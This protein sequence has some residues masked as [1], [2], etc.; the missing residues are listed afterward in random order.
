MRTV[1]MATLCAT[2]IV[3][4]LVPCRAAVKS[5]GSDASEVRAGEAAFQG[6]C[7]VCHSAEPG[8]RLVGPSLYGTTGGA[9]P[10]MTD[11]AVRA[12]VLNGKG[13][14]LDFKGVLSSGDIDN[15]LAYLRTLG[16][17]KGN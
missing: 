9:H 17:S 10:T 16:D 15:L 12:T 8:K 3:T 13:R 5:P 2:A 11:A 4:A 7:A 1:I 14:M 6:N